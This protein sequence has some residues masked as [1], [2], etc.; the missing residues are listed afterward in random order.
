MTQFQLPP[1]PP[2]EK[3]IVEMHMNYL[4]HLR[5]ESYKQGQRDALEAA[6]KVCDARH[7]ATTDGAAAV[8]RK[9]MEEKS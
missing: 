3:T 6:A 5:A 7:H 2:I 8:I 1:E 4:E 9:L